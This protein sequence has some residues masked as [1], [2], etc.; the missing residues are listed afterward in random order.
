[1]RKSESADGYHVTFDSVAELAEHAGKHTARYL[2]GRGYEP[3]FHGVTSF[4][5]V[6]QLATDGWSEE[7]DQAFSVAES[8]LESVYQHHDVPAF[9]AVWGV[10]GCEVDVARYLSGEPE[11]MIDYELVPTTR[12]GRVITLCVSVSVSAAVSN[13]TIKRRGHAIAALTY[14]LSKLGYST[15]IW[16]DSSA[17]SRDEKHRMYMR[18]LVKSAN[19]EYDPARIMFVFAHPAMH[20]ALSLPAMHVMPEDWQTKL[21]VARGC[22][23]GIPMSPKRDLPEGTIYM[24]ELR[25]GVDVPDADVMLIQYMREL[26]IVDD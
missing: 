23:Y 5:E 11:N 9:N 21:G 18:T 13:S 20:R 22:G 19:D 25:S 8:A 15:E 3:R 2:E 17:S 1:M 4:D 10:S 16:A 6:K 24:P 14:A 7:T 26:G 12:V